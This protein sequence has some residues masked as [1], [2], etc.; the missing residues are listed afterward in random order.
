M[1][2]IKRGENMDTLLNRIS[3]NPDICHGKPCI[4]GHRV[5][6]YQILELLENGLSFEQIIRDYFPH[7]TKDDIKVCI[8]YA[9]SI[10]KDE[11]IH[12]YEGT[13]RY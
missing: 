4:K 13:K 7:I 9:N 10:I 6:I 12:F 1:N 8:H 11:E 5:M 2:I 3:A